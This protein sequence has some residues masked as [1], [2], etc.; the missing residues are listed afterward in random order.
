MTISSR[1]IVILVVSAFF[2]LLGIY[3]INRGVYVGSERYVMGAPCCPNTDYIQ[4]RCRYLFITGISE[5]DAIDG[6]VGAPNATHDP[7]ALAKAEKMPDN[8]Y[9][10]LFSPK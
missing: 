8:G 5:I 9:C 6:Q 10:H 3:A 7:A 2:L 4:K 1:L